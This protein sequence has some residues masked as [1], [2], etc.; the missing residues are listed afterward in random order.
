MSGMATVAWASTGCSRSSEVGTPTD[1]VAVQSPA[2]ASAPTLAT[3]T[4]P[5]VEAAPATVI[6]TKVQGSCSFM[7]VS[8]ADYQGDVAPTTPK[9]MCTKYQGKWS[10]GP[11]P[12][13]K[14]QGVCTKLEPPFRTVTYSYPPGTAETAKTACNNTPGGNYSAP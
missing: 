11:C 1:G 6:G 9:A 13:D 5:V 4:A 14:I 7:G 10:D 3:V 12:R 2:V 8:C